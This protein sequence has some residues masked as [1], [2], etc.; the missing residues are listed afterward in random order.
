[1]D[2]EGSDDEGT[3]KYVLPVKNILYQTSNIEFFPGGSHYISDIYL[4]NSIPHVKNI[5]IPPS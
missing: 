2:T 4:S 5:Q 3:W 1:M